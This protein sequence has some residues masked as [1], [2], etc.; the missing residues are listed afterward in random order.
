MYRTR[1]GVIPKSN[2]Y[3]VFI[4]HISTRYN[5]ER[6]IICLYSGILWEVIHMVHE[7][8]SKVSNHHLGHH[9]KWQHIESNKHQSYKHQFASSNIWYIFFGTAI[10][11]VYVT[12]IFHLLKQGT[13]FIITRNRDDSNICYILLLQNY[14]NTLK[15]IMIIIRTKTQPGQ[16]TCTAARGH[17]LNTRMQCL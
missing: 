8:H 13:G 3:M 15:Q 9:F 14:I 12:I 1:L 2:R 7:S 10:V 6:R 17:I 11:H 5:H 16:R 4:I